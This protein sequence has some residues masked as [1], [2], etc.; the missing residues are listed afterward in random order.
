MDPTAAFAAAFAVTAAGG[1]AVYLAMRTGVTWPRQRNV[2]DAAAWREAHERRVAT[3]AEFAEPANK[4]A[5]IVELWPARPVEAR[6]AQREQ[7]REHMQVLER[8]LGT[9]MIDS[10][11]F[12][13]KAA[14]GVVEHCAYFV[15]HLRYDDAEPGPAD[16]LKQ[17]LMVFLVAGREFL[18]SESERHFGLHRSKKRNLFAR[19][20]G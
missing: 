4:I 7:A 19:P 1:T 16:P 3:Y 15:R 2:P 20:S 8:R 18:D 14:R 13:Q 12:V 9:V 11:P 5:D 17:G 6:A 10:N